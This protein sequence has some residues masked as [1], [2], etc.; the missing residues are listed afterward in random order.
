MRKIRILLILSAIIVL[1]P[2][3]Y[4]FFSP[5]LTKI[6]PSKNMCIMNVS[7]ACF[8][9]NEN[10]CK[11]FS[12]PCALPLLWY[13]KKVNANDRIPNVVNT[14]PG[15]KIVLV[16]LKMEPELEPYSERMTPEKEKETAT[17]IEDAAKQVISDLE[18]EGLEYSNV[19]IYKVIPAF[20]IVTTQKGVSFL[21]NHPQVANVSIDK[22]SA[23]SIP[24]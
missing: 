2:I 10:L 21:Q 11:S 6:I 12:N 3:V 19:I 23:P 16:T 4:F 17:R 18:A 24:L 22:P 1:L 14:N 15:R 7:E 20:A 9:G 5:V 8:L 13:P